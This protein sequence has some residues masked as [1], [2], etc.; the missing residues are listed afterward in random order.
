MKA[1]LLTIL[2]FFTLPV[3]MDAQS[4]NEYRWKSRLV[5]LFTPSPSD[6][7]FERQVKLLYEQTEALEERNLVFMFITPDGKF[8]NTG[9]F[10]AEADARKLYQKFNAER[11]HFEM[12]LVGLDG[13]EKF[14]A[15]N[16]ITPPSV[17]FS[18]IDGMPMR[19]RELLQG[20]GTKSTGNTQN[21]G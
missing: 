19:Q 7:M 20:Y 11:Y 15:I 16:R 10:L 5:L 17:L 8:E 21:G 18:L 6:P 4:L 9:R 2:L 13:Y 3:F 12:I 14:R 1:L